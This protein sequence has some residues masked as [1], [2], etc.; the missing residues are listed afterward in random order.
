VSPAPFDETCLFCRIAA[1][2]EPAHVVLNDDRCVAFLD[3]RP[4]FPGHTLLVPRE[5]HETLADLPIERV[6]PLFERAQRLSVAV[7]D[8]AGAAGSFVAMNNVVSQSV[9]HLHVHVV[10]RVKGDGLRGFFWPRTT[11]DGDEHAAAVAERIRA[12]L[13]GP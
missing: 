10:P 5:H 9:P 1:G 6:G 12:E 7:R 2:A 13:A 8:A 3:V 4:L 11:Y